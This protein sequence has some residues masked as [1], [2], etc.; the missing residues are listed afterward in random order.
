[1]DKGG[2]D[3]VAERLPIYLST[4]DHCL[5]ALVLLNA[6]Q[7][8]LLSPPHPFKHTT[9]ST[10]ICLPVLVDLDFHQAEQGGQ[11]KQANKEP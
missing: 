5:M 1:M 10:F 8:R 9:L 6:S 3:F 4:L 2:C 7:V 11:D